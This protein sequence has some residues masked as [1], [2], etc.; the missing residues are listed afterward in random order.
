MEY[1]NDIIKY[2]ANYT[3]K[4]LSDIRHDSNLYSD[5][6]LTSL[7]FITIMYDLEEKYKLN[8]NDDDFINVHQVEDIIII[9]NK[10]LNK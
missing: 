6:G 1:K 2:L 5:L 3:N 7:D 9:F 8:I 4:K 10:Y